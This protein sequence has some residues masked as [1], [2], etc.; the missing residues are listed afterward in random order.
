MTVFGSIADLL[1]EQWAR[2][3]P[4]EQSVLCWLAIAREPVSLE[5][6]RALLV[7]RLSAGQVLEAIEGLRRRSLIE[8]GQRLGS[9]TLQSVVL[10]YVTAHL[11]DLASE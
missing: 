10:E 7:A 6:L 2:L 9:L 8:R 5:E 11:V 4:L 1:D 3:S